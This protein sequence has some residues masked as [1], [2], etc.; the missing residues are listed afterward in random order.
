MAKVPLL[1]LHA[2]ASS[3]A[4]ASYCVFV[5]KAVDVVQ[6]S[7][8]TLMERITM[9]SGRRITAMVLGTGSHMKAMYTKVNG[10]MT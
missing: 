5:V 9:D 2:N 7:F 3:A 1:L 8:T 4:T 6:A 10:M